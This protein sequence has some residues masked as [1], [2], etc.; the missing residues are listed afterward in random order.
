MEMTKQQ[1]HS[2]KKE[3]LERF[4]AKFKDEHYCKD[5]MFNAI[6]EMLIRDADPYSI[7]EKL[8][9]DRETTRKKLEE[10]ITYHS[11]PKVVYVVKQ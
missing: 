4:T 6:I 7:I 5:G 3:V 1:Y 8:L 2:K 11:S 10:F 9:E